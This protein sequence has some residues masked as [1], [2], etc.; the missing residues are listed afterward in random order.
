MLNT[1]FREIISLAGP[2]DT[3]QRSAIATVVLFVLVVVLFFGV[4]STINVIYLCCKSGDYY[5]AKIVVLLVEIFGSI[6]YFYGDNIGY[7]FDRYGDVLGCG[8]VCVENNRIAAIILLGLA[9]IFYQLFP[10]CIRKIAEFKNIEHT[11]H[12]WFSASYMMT[13]ILKIDALFTVV[14]IMAQT[15]DFCS[16]TDLSISVAFLIICVIVGISLMFVYCSISAL[17][18]SNKSDTE[19]WYWIAPFTFAILV[20]AFPLYVLAD[21]LQPLDCA[22]G[23]DSF[24]GNQTLND[25]NCNTTGNSA[26]RLGFTLF[27]F[28]AVGTLS[29]L[30]FCCRSN[31]KTE[32]TAKP[33]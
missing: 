24:A 4:L 12:G 13:T 30:L 19:D 7:I 21:N 18:L 27:T 17:E 16:R 28:I 2:D 11:S 8:Q 3:D 10:V 32:A 25:L 31:T 14:A 23:C 15:S 26:M 20:I 22:W 33:V 5:L 1:I 29:L 9:L 6:L